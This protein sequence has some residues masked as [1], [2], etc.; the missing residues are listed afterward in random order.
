MDVGVRYICRCSGAARGCWRRKLIFG[1][2]YS[3]ELDE[4]YRTVQ[5]RVDGVQK[6]S[7]KMY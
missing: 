7:V 5:Q 2:S 4:L 6:W 1:Q 3:M